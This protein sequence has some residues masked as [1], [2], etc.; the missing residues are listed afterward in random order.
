MTMGSHPDFR[1]DST[2]EEYAVSES[3]QDHLLAFGRD[4]VGGPAE[5]GWQD[6]SSGLM[7]RFGEG[8]E[9][10]KTVTEED[11]DA[12]CDGITA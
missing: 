6:T 10:L 4:P 8:Q 5:I 7:L 1:G 2:E 11:V 3:M 9:V 12:G